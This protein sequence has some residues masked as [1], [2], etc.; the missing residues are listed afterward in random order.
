MLVSKIISL[1]VISIWNKQI[2][3]TVENVLF[4]SKSNKLKYLK[5]YNEKDNFTYFLLPSNIYA[6]NESVLLIKNNSVLNPIINLE[7]STKSCFN[8]IGA[9]IFD[10]DGNNYGSISD[11][12]L[13]NNFKILKVLSPNK[14]ISLKDIFIF[15]ENISFLKPTKNIKISSFAPKNKIALKK[16]NEI[17]VETLSNTNEVLKSETNLENIIKK[18]TT[19]SSSH[20]K[21]II[22]ESRFLLNRIV[23]ENITLQNG[24][25]LIKKN[26]KINSNIIEKARKFGKLIELTQKS[27]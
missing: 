12:E 22:T 4:E 11:L 5:I 10:I 21:R 20:P 2:E 25:V 6:I 26:S 23:Y 3:G 1:Q 9:T 17:I 8:P 19:T 14:E 24:E 15:G 18:D 13:D 27:K 7:L 16:R